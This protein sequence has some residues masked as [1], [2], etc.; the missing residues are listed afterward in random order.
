MHGFLRLFAKLFLNIILW[1]GIS[2]TAF[3][4]TRR[5]ST[6]SFFTRRALISDESVVV[7]E[8]ERKSISDR[9]VVAPKVTHQIIDGRCGSI[10]SL[11]SK[12]DIEPKESVVCVPYSYVLCQTSDEIDPKIAAFSNA[13]VEAPYRLAISLLLEEK[14]KSQSLFLPYIDLLPENYSTP[15]LWTD[16][17][18]EKFPYL[19]MV[20]SVLAQRKKWSTVYESMLKHVP[21]LKDVSTEVI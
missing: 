5:V 19:Y 11:V 3:K 8:F 4:F 14:K 15:L 1:H 17:Q 20:R 7:A 2:I 10:R 13:V 18:L 12:S 9:K 6:R 16:I 21:D